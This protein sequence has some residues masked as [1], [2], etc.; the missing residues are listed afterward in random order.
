MSRSRLS[1]LKH[2]TCA[3]LALAG[4]LCAAEAGLRIY[5]SYTG[6]MRSADLAEPGLTVRSWWTHHSLKPLQR[7]Q[8]PEPE[9]QETI[10]IVTSSHGTRGAEVVVPK[11]PGV[12][13]ILCIGDEI[14]LGADVPEAE[15]FCGRLPA[16]LQGHTQLR[17][18]VVNA[19]V[20]GY[21]PLL[22]YLQLKHALL[23]LQPDLIVLTFDM[24]DVADDHRY[25]RFTQIDD[26]GVPLACP[27][28]ELT[29]R[30]PKPDDMTRHCLLARWVKC[31]LA[32]LTGTAGASEDLRDIDAPQ[33]QYAWIKDN[34]PDWS[35]YVR[36][37]LEPIE[38]LGRTA[39]Q[40]YARL[41]VVVCPA[42]WQVSA[43]ATSGAAARAAAGIPP[44]TL[45]TSRAPFEVLTTWLR[46]HNI[47]ACDLSLSF[48][49]AEQPERLFLTNAPRLSRDGH[50]FVAHHLAA[51]LLQTIPGIWTD[52]SPYRSEPPPPTRQALAVP[53]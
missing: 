19:G 31:E 38:P 20:P 22:S 40:V 30:P 35:V 37:A 33:G 11:P 43:D 45:L 28:P 13:R 49:Q 9:T 8:V 36:Q 15:T 27:H 6:T 50:E 1:G 17:V 53:Q 21:C 2:L 47:A 51:Y 5:D 52:T 42:P 12:Y 26:A 18:E 41:V 3:L 29:G 39:E 32:R 16:L 48:Q 44:D 46:Q 23:A 14:T 24:T 7:L 10:D 34:P 25:R 4:M